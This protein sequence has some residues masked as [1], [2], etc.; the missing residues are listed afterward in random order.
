[1]ESRSEVAKL[2]E[3]IRLSYE[4]A[5]RALN[6]PAMVGRHDFIQKREENIG[7]CFV[8]LTKYVEPNQAVEIIAQVEQEVYGL[9]AGG[10]S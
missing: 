4:A 5:Q 1:M 6:D 3:D 10:T 2:R 9:S 8:E 7:A